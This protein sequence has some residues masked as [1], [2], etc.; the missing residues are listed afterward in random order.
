MFIWSHRTFHTTRGSSPF[1]ALRR[2]SDRSID[3]ALGRVRARGHS[4]GRVPLQAT[5]KIHVPARA[6]VYTASAT[7]ENARR[8]K[9]PGV[10][11]PTGIRLR[12]NRDNRRPCAASAPWRCPTIAQSSSA[13]RSWPL[14]ATLHFGEVSQRHSGLFA[15]LTQRFVVMGAQIAQ[16]M[17]DGLAKRYLSGFVGGFRGCRHGSCGNAFRVFLPPYAGQCGLALVFGLLAARARSTCCWANITARR[18]AGVSS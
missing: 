11:R 2:L 5:A 18:W 6:Q 13:A 9:P 14:L 1:Q 12:R 10:R 16:Y 3:Q 4:Y 15:H 7:K 17:A 8:N